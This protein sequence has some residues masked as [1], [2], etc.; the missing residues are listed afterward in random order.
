MDLNPELQHEVEMALAAEKAEQMD[1]QLSTHWTFADPA[2]TRPLADLVGWVRGVHT[3]AGVV[4]ERT[5]RQ[6]AARLLDSMG[7][8]DCPA[9]TG[10]WGRT[11]YMTRFVAGY[12]RLAMKA[13]WHMGTNLHYLYRDAGQKGQKTGSRQPLPQ[14]TLRE[15]FHPMPSRSPAPRPVPLS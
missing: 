12:G 6:L 13:A 11:R 15:K 2:L 3:Q 4:D 7:L 9:P 10:T 1:A 14:F 8:W 5:D